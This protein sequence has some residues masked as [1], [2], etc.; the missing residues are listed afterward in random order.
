MERPKR[1]YSIHSRPTTKR[2]RRDDAVRWCEAQEKKLV[3]GGHFN[4][5]GR[6]DISA[7]H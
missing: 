6:G 2:N 3:I 7:L 5:A 4:F 1:L